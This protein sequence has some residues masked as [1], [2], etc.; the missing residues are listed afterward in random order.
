MRALVSTVLFVIKDIWRLVAIST[1]RFVRPEPLCLISRSA[2]S[3]KGF[4]FVGAVA[5]Y[6]LTSGKQISDKKELVGT[7][8]R[9]HRFG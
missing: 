2:G 7:L 3:E 6:A 8:S 9:G 4:T 1:R 5:Q